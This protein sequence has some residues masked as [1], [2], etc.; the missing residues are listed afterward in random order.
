MASGAVIQAK[1]GTVTLHRA[2]NCI[3][4]GTVVRVA[5]AVNC[6]IIGNEVNVGQ[7]EGCALAG[8][9]VTIG[10]SMPRRDSEMLVLA[11]RPDCA[12]IDEVIT[13]VGARVAQ[14]GTRHRRPEG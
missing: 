6:E 12:K 9:Q 2:E 11:L 4:S 13:Q 8:R 10:S 3:I 14:F 7:A 1:D 5:H